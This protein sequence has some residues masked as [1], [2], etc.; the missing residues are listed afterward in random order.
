MFATV[1]DYKF[2]GMTEKIFY[3]YRPGHYQV[4]LYDEHYELHTDKEY[5]AKYVTASIRRSG[6]KYHVQ[7]EKSEFEVRGNVLIYNIPLYMDDIVTWSF[8][9][10]EINKEK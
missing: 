8:Y 6:T 5:D 9:G 3:H 1:S 10:Q 4:P 7:L 2:Y